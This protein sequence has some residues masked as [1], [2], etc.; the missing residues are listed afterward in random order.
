MIDASVIEKIMES[1]S[2]DLVISSVPARALCDDHCHEFYDAQ[3]V[4]IED[5]FDYGS[6]DAQNVIIMS[7]DLQDPWYRASHI[8]GHNFVEYPPDMASEKGI[9]LNKPISTTCDCWDEILRVGR[10][11][12][13]RKGVLAHEAFEDTVEAVCAL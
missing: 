1:A 3:V 13:W 11:G 10:Y 2:F 9:L 12:K 4:V 5:T 8:F 7:G 6:V